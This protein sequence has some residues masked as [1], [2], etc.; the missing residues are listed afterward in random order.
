MPNHR[1]SIEPLSRNRA[2]VIADLGRAAARRDN[3]LFR[4]EGWRALASAVTAQADLEDIVVREETLDDDRLEL[5]RNARTK[6]VYRAGPREMNRL[7]SVL[8]D[9]GVVATARIRLGSVHQAAAEKRILALDGVQDP[10]NVG[11][12]I[13]TAAWFGVD[14][15]ISGSDTA[16]FFNPKV[17]RATA[18][19]IWDVTLVRSDD[20]AVDLSELKVH[21]F[22]CFGAD[23]GD[24]ESQEWQSG[25]NSVLVLGS[26]GHGI[27]EPV[28]SHLDGF[29]HLPGSRGPS[30]GVESLNVATAGS[31]LI[32]HWVAQNRG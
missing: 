21:G 28:R 3:G 11:T 27:S 24:A 20:L 19:A 1:F 15:V 2:K 18:G 4:I 25:A 6:A 29:I 9:Q 10:G 17:V 26:E 8:N 12:L 7:T 31:I 16:D 14:A 13:R 32:S 23:L 22:S 5:L 30:S